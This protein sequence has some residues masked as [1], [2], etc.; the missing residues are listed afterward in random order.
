MKEII[1]PFKVG[2]LVIVSLVSFVWMFGQVRE[3]VG[4]S[5]KGY[6]VFA[7]FDDVGG[8]A[9]KS[10]VTI[11][12]INVGQIKK[13]ELAGTK[14]KVW[15]TL[16]TQLKTD[17][18]IAKRQASL[19]G[20]Y[21]LQ[22]TPGYLGEP[23]PHGGEI[24]HVDY[25]T[26]PA[27]LMNDLKGIS[28]NIIE[29]TESLKNVVG[30]KEGQRRLIRILE[31]FEQV[32][33]D[34]KNA[35]GRNAGK[36]DV[37]VDNVIEVTKGAKIFTGN[38]STATR[39]ILADVHK[40]VRNVKNIIGDNTENV[41]SGFEGIKGAVGRLQV[42]LDKLDGTLVHTKSI[43]KKID[44]GDGTL[45]QLINDGQLAKNMNTLMEESGTFVK[46]ITRL[47]TVVGMRSD[48]YTN[49][50]TVRNA[51]EVRLQPRPDKYYTLS[52]IDDPR[53]LTRYR[54]TVTN[55]SN[56]ELDPVIRESE[57]LTEDR[58]RLSLQF[59]KRFWLAT[60]R[61]GII[62]NTGGLGVDTH[63]LN[64]ALEV[65]ADIFAFDANVN[66]RMRVWGTY[67][68]FSHIYLTAGIDEIWNDEL[69]DVF[70]GFGLRFND[71]DLRA[72]LTT[73]PVPAF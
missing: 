37:V 68:F 14:A 5:Q 47:Q 61:I 73:A 32:S 53:G 2:L 29:I 44:T 6:D 11:A 36:F 69:R 51:L 41:Q 16:T 55:T 46:Q 9:E 42:A 20:E 65:S 39:R 67:N 8:L 31:S 57:T 34:I 64:D 33:V 48:V 3:G 72:I 18:R 59:A 49:R 40:I 10:R 1:T 19:L 71:E 63:L 28:K 4:D 58:F 56:S 27:E 54:E 66:P 22:L 43:A 26:A 21:F 50:G 60:G 24:K 52:L 17:A 12:G 38:F 25:D 13:I 30:G 70:I 62:E 7:I 45:S 35:I 23:L 15:L